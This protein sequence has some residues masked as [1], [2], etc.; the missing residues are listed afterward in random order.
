MQVSTRYTK[1]TG[2]VIEKVNHGD[3]RHY[4]LYTHN[5]V[6]PIYK[7]KAEILANHDEYMT[8]A[9]GWVR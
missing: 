8:G 4:S 5:Y 1:E 3:W 9:G 6:G 2:I 7:T